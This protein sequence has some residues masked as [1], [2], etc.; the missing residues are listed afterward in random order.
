VLEQHEKC[1]REAIRLARLAG[2]MTYPNPPVGAVIV[3]DKK[4]VARGF[5]EK[6]GGPHAE[7]S[8]IRA[9][10]EKAKGA[11]LYVTLEPCAHY[12]KTAP[13]V[14]A[15]IKSGIKKVYAGM[16]DP[17]PLVNGKGIRTLRENGIFVK[18]GICKDSVEKL[19]S[20]YVKTLG[21]QGL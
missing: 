10:R 9:A 3:K 7:A 21:S 12:G 15:I 1:M 2:D 14:V 17:N 8:A 19:N 13:C 20:R 16:K 18:V 6:F 4:I 11:S 5:H